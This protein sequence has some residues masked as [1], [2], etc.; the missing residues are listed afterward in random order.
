[1]RTA[2]TFPVFPQLAWMAV[3]FSGSTLAKYTAVD[4]PM[5]PLYVHI[6]VAERGLLSMILNLSRVESLFPDSLWC[7]NNAYI[8]L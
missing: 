1:M 3:G 7:K 8:L 6:G 5:G 2:R 4:S